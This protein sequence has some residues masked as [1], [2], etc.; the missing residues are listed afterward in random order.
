LGIPTLD[1]S[2]SKPQSII[3][4]VWTTYAVL[5]GPPKVISRW[6]PLLDL[7]STDVIEGNIILAGLYY[8]H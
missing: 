7:G 6:Q 3:T 5:V 4:A 2:T 8:R 1:F